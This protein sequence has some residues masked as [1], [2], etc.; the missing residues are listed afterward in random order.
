MK[1]LNIFKTNK[2]V[3]KSTIEK[4]NKS[5]LE[6]IVGGTQATEEAGQD[7]SETSRGRM[8]SADITLER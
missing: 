4:V 5:Q 7:S 1:L 2:T 3:V 6:K 8:K